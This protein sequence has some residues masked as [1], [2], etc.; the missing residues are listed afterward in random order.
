MQGEKDGDV[1][2]LNELITDVLMKS[3]VEEEG[4]PRERVERALQRFREARRRQD[5][6]GPASQRWRDSENDSGAKGRR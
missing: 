6:S 3:L 2:E 5:A 4:V 1:N